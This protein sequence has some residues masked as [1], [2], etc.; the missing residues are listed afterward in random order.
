MQ[1]SR[2]KRL[3]AHIG[4]AFCRVLETFF[5]S[6]QALTLIEINNRTC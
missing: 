6:W 4:T 1:K 2:P 3:F 5:G